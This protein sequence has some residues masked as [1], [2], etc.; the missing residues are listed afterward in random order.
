MRRSTST[1]IRH[2]LT[3][4]VLSLALAPAAQA[5]TFSNLNVSRDGSVRGQAYGRVVFST[6]NNW[7][8]ANTWHRST[9]TSYQ[10]STYARNYWQQYALCGRNPVTGARYMMYC[11][12]GNYRSDNTNSTTYRLWGTTPSKSGMA[13]YYYMTPRVCIDVRF[14][15]DPCT[16]G[17]TLISDR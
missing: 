11:P 16:V 8:V 7:H 4:L 12:R 9:S 5:H 2:L 10:H 1:R 3:L 15:S 17:P 13:G 14:K 6:V